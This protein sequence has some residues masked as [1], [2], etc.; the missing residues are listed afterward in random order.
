MV[1]QVCVDFDEVVSYVHYANA[2]TF[3]TWFGD[4]QLVIFEVVNAVFSFNVSL[5]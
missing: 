5:P 1:L 4:N 3:I 2:S